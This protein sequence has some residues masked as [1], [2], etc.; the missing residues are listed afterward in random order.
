VLL[1]F[2]FDKIREKQKRD[3]STPGGLERLLSTHPL[4][5]DRIDNVKSQLS[6]LKINPDPT[7]GLNITE[8]QRIKS[9][10]P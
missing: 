4:P 8:Y 2:F 7:K 9:L 10:L 6:I 1:S 3:G 5:Q